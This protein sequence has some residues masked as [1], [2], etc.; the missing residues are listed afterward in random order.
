MRELSTLKT[1]VSNGG[2]GEEQQSRNVGTRGGFSYARKTDK[3]RSLPRI[4]GKMRTL[5]PTT[6]EDL[7]DVKR[8]KSVG[9]LSDKS[10]TYANKTIA[11]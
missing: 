4:G 8:L 11:H 3:A 10:R 6:Q 7:E 5:L 1:K 9:G 2:D